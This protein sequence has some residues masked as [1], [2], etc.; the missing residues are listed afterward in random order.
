MWSTALKSTITVTT[1]QDGSEISSAGGKSFDLK[2]TTTGSAT[3][4]VKTGT[5]RPDMT[6]EEFENKLKSSSMFN[7]DLFDVTREGPTK[8]IHV[9]RHLQHGG[10]GA[11][12]PPI[13]IASSSLDANV[14]LSTKE[15]KKATPSGVTSS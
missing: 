6:A 1:D 15:I 5:F 12:Q 11:D 13:E 8:A 14:Q 3:P 9:V 10:D 4:E 2:F 7:M